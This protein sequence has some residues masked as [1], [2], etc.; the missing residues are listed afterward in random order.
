MFEFG[1]L[2]ARRR[3]YPCQ[4]QSHH[5]PRLRLLP[6]DALMSGMHR[7]ELLVYSSV[8]V[9]VRD[10]VYL[11]HHAATSSRG[12]SSPTDGEFRAV[13]WKTYAQTIRPGP[14]LQNAGF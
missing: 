7:R 1:S 2:A 12:F 11:T 13:T 8:V 6:S 9:I 3:R 14:L 4:G 5:P 10:I